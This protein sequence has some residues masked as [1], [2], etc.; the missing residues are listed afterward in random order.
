MSIR[1]DILNEPLDIPRAFLDI[2]GGSEAEIS[3][4][5][6]DCVYDEGKGY[7]TYMISS[8]KGAFVLKRYRYP[9]D[10]EAE[11]RQY[12]RLRGLPVPK[13]LGASE[14]CIL[15]GFVPGDDLKQPSDDGIRAAAR[16][17]AKI[18]N[19][20]PM[21]R[22][23][24]QSRYDRYL[25][26]LEKRAEYLKDEPELKKA[27]DIFFERQKR[28]PLTISNADLLPI[29]VLYDGNKA[30]LIDWEFGGFL[31]YSLDIARFITH[32]T[33][34]GEVTSF[35]MSGEQKKLFL[36]LV[37]EKLFVKPSR[38]VFDMDVLLA[39]L[40]ECVEILEYYLGDPTVERGAVFE[41][42]YPMAKKLAADI[43][44]NIT[45]EDYQA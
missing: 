30:T 36:D 26:R 33:E 1:L 15:M 17:L 41:L 25:K 21:G 18:I 22:G 43:T 13:L 29:N 5:F 16:S 8:E 45:L 9:E 35:R 28:I 14:N 44:A 31:P 7:N 37:Y 40:N 38:D 4:F 27:F 6:D 10:F 23:Y 12:E 34:N 2:T 42:Y 11:V 32:C 39:R 24:E 19:A 3:R 20:Y